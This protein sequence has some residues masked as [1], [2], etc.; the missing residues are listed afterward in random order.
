MPLDVNELRREKNTP[1]KPRKKTI[2]FGGG[3]FHFLLKFSSHTFRE[4]EPNFTSIFFKGVWF[5]HQLV[6]VGWRAVGD[7]TCR[8]VAQLGIL[9]I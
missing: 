3:L 1:K 2:C 4:D 5:N 8:W 9:L 7:G 6:S